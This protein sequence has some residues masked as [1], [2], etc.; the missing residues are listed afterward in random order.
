MLRNVRAKLWFVTPRLPNNLMYASL[1]GSLIYLSTCTRPD[2][3]YAVSSLSRFTVTP[4]QAHWRAAQRVLVYLRKY[5][6]LGIRYCH[7]S[8]LAIQAYSDASF[9]EDPAGRR[10]QTGMAILASGGVV[11]WASKRQITPAVSTGEAEYQALAAT[12]R[13]VQWFKH[14]RVDL[15]LPCKLITIGCDSTVAESWSAE[16]ALVPRAKHIDIMHHY[17]RDLAMSGRI[18]IQHVHTSLQL[19]DTLTK[20]LEAEQFWFLNGLLGMVDC[21][22]HGAIP[23]MYKRSP[24]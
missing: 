5:P 13:D 21:K 1:I 8:E 24:R 11:H 17:V 18:G 6:N 16:V 10:S 4:T 3:A 20:A 22:R 7:S 9:G 19:A 2:I 23:P 14:L 12:A 15:G